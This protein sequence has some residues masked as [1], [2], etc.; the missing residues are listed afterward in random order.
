M[1]RRLC[2]GAHGA[3]ADGL[4]ENAR[5]RV[6]EATPEDWENVKELLAELGRPDVRDDPAE[7]EH[8]ARFERYLAR[9]DALALVAEQ[10]GAVVGFVDVEFRQRLNF[11][12]PEA[13]VPDL[14]VAEAARGTGAGRALL[15]EVER[16]ALERDSWGMALESANWRESSHAF[17]EHVGWGDVAKA[18][19]R[20]FG[21]VEWPPRPR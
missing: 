5:V 13:W 16:R 9:D 11:L 1:G 20:T 18:F 17:Y 10:D 8:Q 15:A 21:D 3:A 2:G 14:V 19:S 7:P 12:Q 6:R 4:S